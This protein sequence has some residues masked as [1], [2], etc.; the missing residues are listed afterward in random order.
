MNHEKKILYTPQ[1]NINKSKTDTI[2]ISK[3]FN[4]KDSIQ[5]R[6]Y[7]TIQNILY[8]KWNEIIINYEEYTLTKKKELKKLIRLGIPDNLRG[9]LW[10]KFGLINKENIKN[11]YNE[12]KLNNKNLENKNEEDIIKDLFRTS[13]STFF[14]N[15]F[16]LGQINL[17]NVLS[18][19][20]NQSETGYVQGMSF[21]CAI[22]LSYMNE[23]SSFWM[24]KSLMDKYNMKGYFQNDFPEL[25][26]SYFKLLKLLKSIFPKIYYTLK[27]WKILPDYY[28]RQWFLTLFFLDVHYDVFLR[29]L[30]IFLFENNFKIIY[31]I[32]LA[33]LKLNQEKIFQAQN[34]SD[35]MIIFKD[36][37]KNLTVNQLFNEGFNIKIKIQNLDKFGFEYEELKEKNINDEIMEQLIN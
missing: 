12:Y 24:M 34:F 18:T 20:S 23:E 36:I 22:F 28:A 19:F 6:N 14:K 5:K 26:K 27:K 1:Y 29:I 17:Y 11:K 25:K 4:N 7:Y 9:Y 37:G 35:L 21:L 15:K 2:K 31:R 16:G 13:H 3:T 33:L 8:N 10:Q 32:S 30:D